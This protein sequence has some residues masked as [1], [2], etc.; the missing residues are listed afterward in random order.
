MWYIYLLVNTDTRR[1]YI[2][3]TT[4]LARRL[5]QHNREIV[6]GARSTKSGAPNW[7]IYSYLSGLENRSVAMRW[8]KILKCRFRGFSARDIAFRH[9]AQGICP[10]KGK[11]YPVPT[12]VTYDHRS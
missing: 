9:V 7:L 11:Q 3:V 4:N 5:R 8:E 10:G 2:G 12:G 6:G 1:S